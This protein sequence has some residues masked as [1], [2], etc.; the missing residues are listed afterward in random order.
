MTEENNNATTANGVSA[1]EKP[2]ETTQQNTQSANQQNNQLLAGK[3]K[4]TEDL[5][6]G[7]QESG[8]YIRD[9]SA[10]LKDYETKIPKAPENYTFDFSQDQ[11]LKDLNLTED[12]QVKKMLPIFKELNISQ[13]QATKLISEFIRT[14]FIPAPTQ[15]DFKKV[16]GADA[17]V[18]I[19]RLQ[20]F[21]SN[22]PPKD[23]EIFK[24]LAEN[25]ESVEFLYRYILP[26]EDMSI[27]NKQDSENLNSNNSTML[28]EKA[29]SYREEK[30]K[31]N[32]FFDQEK[33]IYAEMLKEASAQKIKEEKR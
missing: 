15:E 12:E 22:L 31:Q 33:T 21:N 20:L 5:V 28:Y 7:Y 2:V 1:T 4:T 14:S 25:P 13:D 23:Q 8:K 27:P 17:E 24:R 29:F 3:Y 32:S 19:G 18:K 11:D 6:K 26:K 30:Q 16:L 10:K 9:L